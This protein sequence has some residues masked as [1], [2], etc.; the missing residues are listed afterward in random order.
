MGRQRFSFLKICY[1]TFQGVNFLS[2]QTLNTYLR[3]TL[4]ACRQSFFAVV[5]FSFFVN[6]F[7]LTV[8]IYLLQL[9]DRVIPNRST[10]TLIFLTLIAVAAL[11]TL[12]ILDAIRSSILMRM[13]AWLDRRLS[14]H[15]IS[16]TV[17]RSLSKE[18]PSSARVLN[19]LAT[20]RNFFSDPTLITILDL[21]WAPIFTAVLFLLHPLIG[22]ITLI[23]LILLAGLAFLN[24]YLSRSL[25]KNSEASSSK[26]TDYASSVIKNSDVIEAM[27]MRRNFLNQWNLKNEKSLANYAK[28]ASK[29][30][31]IS[32]TAKFLR[33]ALQIS[34]VFSAA[35]LI[36]ND[37][38][39][40]GA[41]MA[42][43]LLMRRAISPMERAISSWKSVLKARNALKQVSSRLD[44][45]PTLKP[46]PP[47]AQ[48]SGS[49]SIEKLTYAYSRNA[50]PVLYK[51]NF[52]TFPG[53]SLGIG[54]PTAAGKSTLARLLVGIAKP[55]SGHVKL[56]GI[57]I[58]QWDSDELG[59]YIG[60]LPQ[61]VELFAG[62]FRQNIARMEEGD[63]NDVIDS[64]KLAGVH[65]LIMQFP[66]GYDTEIGD[67][68]AFLS[69]GQRQ[70]IALARAAY[71]SPKL[72]VL[73]E[74]DA[75]LDR[76]G[77]D[78]LTNAIKNLKKKGSMVILI[79]HQSDM[80]KLTDNVIMLK[81]SK[82][83]RV[84]KVSDKK[85]QPPSSHP[86]IA[87]NTPSTEIVETIEAIEN[88]EDR[89]IHRET[90][91]YWDRIGKVM[92]ATST[93]NTSSND[94]FLQKLNKEKA[95]NKIPGENN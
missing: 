53:T 3:D 29:T 79:S 67:G 40:G 17:R 80:L 59:P 64:A 47:L 81:K 70:R 33:F 35:W 48:P 54:G 25:V 89:V 92:P 94:R 8:P 73:D 15:I 95:K 37:Q 76:E 34:V 43:V 12:S 83:E 39:T 38:L 75:N 13:G 74:P 1:L 32:T 68:G 50:K 58:T 77:K 51:I 7:M 60:F 4:N 18:K 5:L 22:T 69:G 42:S 93:D 21:P 63:I 9:Y 31:W 86:P 78:A 87:A 52:E 26:L 84:S 41:M 19:D 44:I 62:T 49:L 24:E 57:N 23:G 6:I 11:I 20:L 36:M 2:K 61:D 91:N 45:A 90:A 30:G 56:G 71:K 46:Y 72:V 28:T 27:G 55:T 66:K 14:S 88:D 65:K 10:E 82:A 16:G 85:H